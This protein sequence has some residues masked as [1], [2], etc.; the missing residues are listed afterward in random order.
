MAA[1][2][3]R[4]HCYKKKEGEK[5]CLP[6]GTLPSVY[7][8]AHAGPDVQYVDGFSGK[9]VPLVGILRN[10]ENVLLKVIF[11]YDGFGLGL[12]LVRVDGID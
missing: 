8:T 12:G 11:G 7:G 10:L 9:E 3:Y 5:S 1:A 6:Q 4:S 2:S